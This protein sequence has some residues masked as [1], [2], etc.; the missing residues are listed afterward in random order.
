MN[1]VGHWP[2]PCRR[3]FRCNPFFVGEVLRHLAESRRHRRAGRGPWVSDLDPT[4]VGILSEGI[5]EVVGRRLTR[6]GP[7][8]E[9]ILSTA[10]V[11]DCVAVALA[12]FLPVSPRHR[13]DLRA[14]LR[15]GDHECLAVLL[16]NLMAMSRVTST[17][18]F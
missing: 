4:D 11:I 7:E 3:T 18:C 10:A 15:L 14:D 13:G 17:C 6:L 9:R 8:V 1:R 2:G 5:R 12:H 16:L